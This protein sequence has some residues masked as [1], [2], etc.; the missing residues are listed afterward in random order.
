MAFAI[1]LIIVGVLVLLTTFFT[2]FGLLG[3]IPLI[4]GII[5]VVSKNKKE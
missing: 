1:I 2:G 5:M 3:I 4:I